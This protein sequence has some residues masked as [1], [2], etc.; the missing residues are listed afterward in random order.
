MIPRMW[1]L[2]CVC[3][4][5]AYEC[6]E[7]DTDAEVAQSE[8]ATDEVAAMNQT[9]TDDLYDWDEA[10][11]L[12]EKEALEECKGKLD[13]T[14]HVCT[15]LDEATCWETFIH[16][17]EGTYIQCGLD[18]NMQ[19]LSLG[20]ICRGPPL[21]KYAAMGA[22]KCE[23]K[24]KAA[25]PG[26]A[27][28]DLSYTNAPA[29]EKKEKCYEACIRVYGEECAGFQYTTSSKACHIYTTEGH[30]DKVVTTT[31]QKGPQLC[32]KVNPASESTE[33]PDFWDAPFVNFKGDKILFDD[34]TI[35]FK[36]THYMS[37]MSVLSMDTMK[38]PFTVKFTIKDDA[39]V[40]DC[41]A[42]RNLP[43]H[44]F[45]GIIKVGDIKI[46]K[47]KQQKFTGINAERNKP[48]PWLRGKRCKKAAYLKQR[49]KDTT[50]TIIM[51]ED[52]A[53]QLLD[54]NG[55]QIITDEYVNTDNLPSKKYS[56]T[57]EFKLYFGNLVYGSG[58]KGI[59]YEVT[60]IEWAGPTPQEGAAN[61]VAST[62]T[63]KGLRTLGSGNRPA[64][65]DLPAI[66]ANKFVITAVKGGIRGS[67]STAVFGSRGSYI[68]LAITKVP[69]TP[70]ATPKDEPV[71]VPTEA[72]TKSFSRV[73]YNWGYFYM[74]DS[75]YWD[76][77]TSKATL[78][79]EMKEP[80]ALEAG[81][82]ALWI[83]E[84]LYT[85][86]EGD[87]GYFYMLDSKY[88]DTSTSKATLT[89]EMKEPL[90]LEAG[91]YALWIGEDL[92][93]SSEGDNGGMDL[94]VDMTINP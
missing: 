28:T 84:D 27:M 45:F 76:T 21:A 70:E 85:S 47:W 30:A 3:I 66:K 41:G 78:T 39:N 14:R 25:L 71:I 53:V 89:W 87:N 57:D 79:W 46:G 22:G 83:G 23:D 55:G 1:A 19:C 32:Y 42:N 26:K 37:Q 44:V 49:Q 91:K 61:S 9:V 88:W 29:A 33:H 6:L 65:F 62:V 80:L 54:E 68:E 34:T 77:S 24:K 86:S 75:K 35:K 13:Q 5:P 56:P 60:N 20:G 2:I 81:K 94:T 69:W 12:Q 11:P 4:L 7:R 8:E 52:G 63:V 16:A 64:Q 73:S 72:T 58:E 40:R 36:P 90:A 48:C 93:T 31:D 17:A 15:G 38:P 74:L 51:G 43:G 18:A 82:Y 50:Y 10:P 67:Q 92:Y 59:G